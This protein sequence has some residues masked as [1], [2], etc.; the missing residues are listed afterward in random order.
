MVLE[1]SHTS[2]LDMFAP[3]SVFSRLANRFLKDCKEVLGMVPDEVQSAADAVRQ[4]KLLS[5]TEDSGKIPRSYW[6]Y[7][8]YWEKSW[9]WRFFADEED[10]RYVLDYYFFSS[11]KFD[12]TYCGVKHIAGNMQ[13]LRE[14]IC[15]RK[16]PI[17]YFCTHR[18]PARGCIPEGFATYEEYPRGQR[19][20]GEVT[21]FTP[22]PD[23]ELTRWGLQLDPDWLCEWSVEGFKIS[24]LNSDVEESVENEAV[25][26]L[27]R[28]SKRQRTG[29][30]AA[31][32]R[33]GQKLL[34]ARMEGPAKSKYA[35][36][37]VCSRCVAHERG[38][39]CVDRPL[40]LSKWAYIEYVGTFGE[41]EAP[42]YLARS[43][44]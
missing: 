12:R 44:L 25:R 18:P 33:C 41:N 15:R 1:K 26:L 35:D 16:G 11:E 27:A 22:P 13:E 29:K 4:G 40:P 36:V 32:P 38:L 31:C 37:T 7:G 10:G 20:I 42:K 23:S 24:H 21:Y 39:D 9:E 30:N 6:M 28:L 8:V 17:R 34:S 43:E 5:D 19:W 3:N 2:N 14:Q